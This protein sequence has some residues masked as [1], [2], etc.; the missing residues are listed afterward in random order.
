M[1]SHTTVQTPVA[2]TPAD[3]DLDLDTT[4][5]TGALSPALGLIPGIYVTRRGEHLPIWPHHH[6]AAQPKTR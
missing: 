4:D 5:T 1:S 2:T 6:R 3:A